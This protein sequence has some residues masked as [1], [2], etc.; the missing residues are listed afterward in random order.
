[1]LGELVDEKGFGGPDGLVIEGELFAE[2]VVLVLG[3]A[4]KDDAGSG[5][6]VG[7]AVL[8]DLLLAFGGARSSGMLRWPG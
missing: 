4:G 8:R 5:E 1:M 3:F 7:E 2:G 6:P